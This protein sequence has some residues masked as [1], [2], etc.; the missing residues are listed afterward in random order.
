MTWNVYLSGEIHSDWRGQIIDHVKQLKL[1]VEFTS[2][3]TDQDAS[4]AAG[5][6]LGRFP[7]TDHVFLAR[8][9][10]GLHD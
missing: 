1:P 4:D 3:V 2:A 8:V 7:G 10:V 6:G 9:C 5:D